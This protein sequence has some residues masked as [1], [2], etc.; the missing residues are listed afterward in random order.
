MYL[1]IL[2]PRHGREIGQVDFLVSSG[3]SVRLPDLG[4]FFGELGEAE[5][6]W[7]N[8][9]FIGSAAE[10]GRGGI[11]AR[12]TDREFRVAEL[13]RRLLLSGSREIFFGRS[14]NF[15]DRGRMIWAE[16]R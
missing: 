11:P 3:P 4:G 9:S 2:A 8:V 15:W 6:R 7:R 1:V 14:A 10:S 5:W 16:K 12:E 13:I